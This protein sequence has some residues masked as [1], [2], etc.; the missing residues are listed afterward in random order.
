MKYTVLLVLI[1]LLSVAAGLAKVAQVPNEMAFLQGL[2]LSK[3]LIL[4]FGAIQ[5]TAGCMVWVSAVR[6]LGLWFVFLMFLLSTAMLF[7]S[8]DLVFG[9]ISVVP[10]VLTGFLIFR[11]GKIS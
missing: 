9:L 7:V 11:S 8:G 6:P 1:S 3:E 4:L 5:I 2:G 10:V